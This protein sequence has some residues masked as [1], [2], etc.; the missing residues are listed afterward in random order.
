MR[1]K[2]FASN[3]GWT[4][5]A[6]LSKFGIPIPQNNQRKSLGLEE[7]NFV[8]I[9]RERKLAY[10]PCFSSGKDGIYNIDLFYLDNNDHHTYHYA[11]LIGVQAIKEVNITNLR[12]DLNLAGLPN[13]VAQDVVFQT[14]YGAPLFQI[15]LKKWN[16]LFNCNNIIAEK[17]SNRFIVNVTYQELIQV[18][19]V[20]VNWNNLKFANR[21]YLDEID[22]LLELA[23]LD[24]D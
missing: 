22:I 11:T 17:V 24:L 5:P 7:F 20:S 18:G 9:L 19:R 1:A 4:S 12:E 3:N 10:L 13:M 21:L 14:N 16:E 23:A 8:D 6:S 2:T 15:A